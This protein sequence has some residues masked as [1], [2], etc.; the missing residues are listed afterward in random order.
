MVTENLRM[1][2][3]PP[4]DLISILC[5]QAITEMNL[6]LLSTEEE[7]RDYISLEDLCPLIHQ[8]IFSNHIKGVFNVS[9]NITLSNY[10]IASKVRDIFF[11]LQKKKYPS[12]KFQARNT[13]N[14]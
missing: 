9:S 8:L 6:E 13:K 5:K 10:D 7:L 12:F 14:N 2:R 3:Y 4:V 1:Y 11:Q